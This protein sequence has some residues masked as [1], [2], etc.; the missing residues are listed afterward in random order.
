MFE[1]YTACLEVEEQRVEL[2]LWDTSGQA[3]SSSV[4]LHTNEF[5]WEFGDG[6]IQR[7]PICLNLSLASEQRYQHRIQRV[8][9]GTCL[10]KQLPQSGEKPPSSVVVTVSLFTQTTLSVSPV[11]QQ[12]KAPLLQGH[13]PRH[14]PQE[15][16]LV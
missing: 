6:H 5:M 2:S 1:N 10:P 3:F 12:L 11:W 7:Q 9:C 14:I 13:L 16:E 15:S 4:Y 8:I